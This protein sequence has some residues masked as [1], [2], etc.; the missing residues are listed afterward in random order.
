[1]D[2]PINIRLSERVMVARAAF[3]SLGPD[4]ETGGQSRSNGIVRA[5]GEEIRNRQLKPV[6][7]L[8]RGKSLGDR[9]RR[10]RGGVHAEPRREDG[11]GF[12]I[13]ID[14]AVLDVRG[15]SDLEAVGPARTDFNLTAVLQ[16]F[17]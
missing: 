11:D 8:G 1:P 9:S 14:I 17:T 7:L 15:E 2:L 3:D 5:E 6:T 12:P 4:K 16:L 13:V 10:G